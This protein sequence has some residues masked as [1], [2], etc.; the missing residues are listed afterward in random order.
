MKKVTQK[1]VS[2]FLAQKPFKQTN[3]LVETLGEKTYLYLH[4]NRIA[5]LRNGEL[6]I[7]NCGWFTNTTKERLNALPNV[8]I[9]QKNFKWYLNGKEWNGELTKVN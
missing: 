8:S 5:I 3:T 6:F 9:H 1:A 2:N 7:S 4:G